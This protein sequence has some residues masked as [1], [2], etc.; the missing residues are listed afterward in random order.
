MVDEG[1]VERP[2]VVGDERDPALVA[3]SRE[4]TDVGARAVVGGGED[5]RRLGLRVR[6][7]RGLHRGNLDAVGEL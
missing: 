6:P 7:Q 3:R 2:G 5:H 1:V 4:P